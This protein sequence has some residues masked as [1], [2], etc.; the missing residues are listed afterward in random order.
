MKKSSR[1]MLENVT[2]FS[3]SECYLGYN[4]I[5]PVFSKTV[6][7]IDM[8]GNIVKKW[9]TGYYPGTEGR[10]ISNGN[11]LFAGKDE[12]GPLAH[13]EGAGGILRELSPDNEVVW[14]YKDPYLHHRFHRLE[15]GNTLVLKWTEVPAETA[16]KVQ[17]GFEADGADGKMWGD[18]IQE[19]TPAGECVWEWKAHE[20]LDP[21]KDKLCLLCSRSEW[22][23]A[24]SIEVFD[25]DEKILVNFMRIHTLA[26]IDKK[27]GK[28]EW[29]WGPGQVSHQNHA[30]MMWDGNVM[31]FDNGRHIQ[32]EAWSYSRSVIVDPKSSKIVG[33]YEEDP[34]NFFQTPFLGNAQ[35]LANNGTLLVEG[36]KGRL[37]EVSYRNSMTWEYVNPEWGSSEE[38]GENNYIAS[39]YR[40]GLDDIGLQKCLGLESKWRDWRDVVGAKK[41]SIKKETKSQADVVRDRLANLGY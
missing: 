32:G 30:T 29:K 25:N 7:L 13:F 33:G 20:H 36:V 11:L 23:H 4:L 14:E 37:L 38:Y 1:Q 28:I 22:T 3:P 21:E 9:D 35:P 15:N 40:Y 41:E 2:F 8:Q 12:N 16:A 34:P 24:T 26:V 17:G 27:S 18:V 5:N 6:R 19:I 39:A 10:I 31:V